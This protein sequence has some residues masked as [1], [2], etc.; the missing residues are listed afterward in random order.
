[1][2]LREP[3][4]REWPYRSYCVLHAVDPKLLEEP[5]DKLSRIST[6]LVIVPSEKSLK[7]GVV[8]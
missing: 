7:P 5:L 1:V 3:I 6:D 8:R 2:V 4:G